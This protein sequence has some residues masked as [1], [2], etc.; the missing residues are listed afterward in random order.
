MKKAYNVYSILG[1]TVSKAAMLTSVFALCFL[2]SGQMFSQSAVV[3]PKTSVNQNLQTDYEV[4]HGVAV[5]Y[6]ALQ[7]NQDRLDKEL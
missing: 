7:N 5:P 3:S 2:F 6:T 4:H 1:K